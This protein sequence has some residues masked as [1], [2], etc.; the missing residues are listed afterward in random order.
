MRELA[1]Q[2]IGLTLP[3]LEQLIKEAIAWEPKKIPWKVRPVFRLN[4][5]VHNNHDEWNIII[6]NSEEC[7]V[8]GRATIGIDSR[9]TSFS[10]PAIASSKIELRSQV[11]STN[12]LN[13]AKL[14]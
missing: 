13:N 7:E 2:L 5:N 6:N 9:W 3:Q 8:I 12:I 10:V 1:K 14:I 4:P 11:F